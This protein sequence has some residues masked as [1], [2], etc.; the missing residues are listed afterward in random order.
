MLWGFYS[1]A[2]GVSLENLCVTGEEGYLFLGITS[3]LTQQHVQEKW[4]LIQVILSSQR[5][6][7]LLDQKDEQNHESH[8]AGTLGTE[9]YGF[10]A[11]FI[12]LQAI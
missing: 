3:L 6:W 11:A 8:W 1:L 7:C 5:E 4:H 12:I 2:P 10:Y 9:V